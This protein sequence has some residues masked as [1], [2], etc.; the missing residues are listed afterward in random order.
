MCLS[1]VHPP[2]CL[3]LVLPPPFVEAV[4]AA[5]TALEVPDEDD[6]LARAERLLRVVALDEDG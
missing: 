1:R 6:E 2:Y 5:A 4:L 3:T